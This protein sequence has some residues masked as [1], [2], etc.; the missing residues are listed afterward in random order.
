MFAALHED[1]NEHKWLFALP[2][3]CSHNFSPLMAFSD[4]IGDGVATTNATN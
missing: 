2:T 3:D 4:F 1:I